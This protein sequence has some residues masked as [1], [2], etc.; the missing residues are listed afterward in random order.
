MQYITEIEKWFEN[1][2]KWVLEAERA[3]RLGKA[4]SQEDKLLGVTYH[5]LE[6]LDLK[7]EEMKAKIAE[8]KEEQR[9]Q[10]IEWRKAK[11]L[12]VQ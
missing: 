12:E 10:M 1:C 6:E 8:I 3:K 5:S 11:G 4:W 7:A 9:K 2:Y